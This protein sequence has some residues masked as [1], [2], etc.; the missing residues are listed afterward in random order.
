MPRAEK[1]AV[2]S[3]TAITS[4]VT[5]PRR[6]MRLRPV[7]VIATAT[8]LSASTQQT[9]LGTPQLVSIEQSPD[10]GEMC[11]WERASS[12]GPEENNLFAAFHETSVLAASQQ[13]GQTVDV[14]RPP[15]RNILDTDPIYTSVTVDPRNNEVYLQDSNTWSIRVFSRLEN[16]P[17]T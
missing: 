3:A 13:S 4:R 7:L 1:V 15:L 8:L 5:S 6:H 2:A 14:N 12:S 17:A 9:K 10:T 16:T 11:Y